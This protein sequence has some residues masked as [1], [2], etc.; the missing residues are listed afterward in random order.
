MQKQ[1]KRNSNNKVFA[2]VCSGIANYAN[3]D[4]GV[5]RFLTLLLFIFSGGIVLI[6]YIILAI[7]LPE[8][9][10]LDGEYKNESTDAFN[11]KMKKQ[12]VNEYEFDQSDYVIDK[13]EY[14]I[15]D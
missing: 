11:Q 1:L 12:P 14:K 2:G 10:L 7:A 9:D 5:V 8:D 3:L 6:I 4:V 15:E 13:D